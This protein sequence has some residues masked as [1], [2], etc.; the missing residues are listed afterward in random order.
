MRRVL[1]TS[2]IRNSFIFLIC[3]FL[4]NCDNNIE[5]IKGSITFPSNNSSFKEGYEVLLGSTVSGEWYSDVDGYLGNGDSLVVSLTTGNHNILL[6]IDG[7][8]L[9]SISLS[10]IQL[11]FDTNYIEYNLTGY[12]N[13]LL[14]PPGSR[15][16]GV[17]S[18]S[19]NI[20]DFGDV[21][22]RSI[23]DE[24]NHSFKSYELLPPL[25]LHSIT[26]NNK[27]SR[28]IHLL[29]R[30]FNIIDIDYGNS[31]AGLSITANNIYENDLY[32]LWLDT[33]SY[34]D[35]EHLDYLTGELNSM[36][37]EHEVIWGESYD[38]DENTKLSILMSSKLN[39]TESIIGYFNPADFFQY[40]SDVDSDAYNPVSNEMDIIYVAAPN[41]D[42]IA[43]SLDSILAT[44]SHELTHLKNYSVKYRS[45]L[46]NNLL[47][48]ESSMTFI[49]E[50]LAHLSE[51]LL[52]YGFSGGNMAF[53]ASYL[54][55]SFSIPLNEIG[56]ILGGDS[57]ERRGGMSL[58]FSWI[59]WYKG[60]MDYNNGYVV[61]LGGISWLKKMQKSNLSGW[62]K[63]EVTTGMTQKDIYTEFLA[64]LLA[65]ELWGD[66]NHIRRDED[67][68][69]NPYYGSYMF[70]DSEYNLDGLV[71]NHQNFELYP[72]SLGFYSDFNNTEYYN[73]SLTSDEEQNN[74]TFILY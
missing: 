4:V 61:D 18:L 10:I 57:V 33:D 24:N 45:F 71:R 12:S 1:N 50:G 17:Y 19:D 44:I 35:Q 64:H 74:I 34:I 9:D 37:I 25:D 28:S 36:L 58:L 5:E 7:Q 63:I 32:A 21:D 68:T 46:S 66:I 53:V 55:N 70:N 29:E 39:D 52:G 31:S 2:L 49:E 20:V 22:D 16:L 43:Y 60:G 65:E 67:I 13:E 48:L 23:R 30:D 15:R 3:L 62:E 11:G 51:N 56:N 6:K 42:S 40:S 27:N 47:S 72:Y 69:I 14:I 38:V 54:N 41:E 73:L 26:L 59:F 8:L